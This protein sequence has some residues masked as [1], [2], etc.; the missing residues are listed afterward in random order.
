MGWVREGW[1]KKDELVRRGVERKAGKKR[2]KKV[3]ERKGDRMENRMEESWRKEE[4]KERRR[5][6]CHLNLELRT[7]NYLFDLIHSYFCT[8]IQYNII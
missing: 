4:A 8:I 5:E 6:C 7:Q 2:E 3:D 1:E